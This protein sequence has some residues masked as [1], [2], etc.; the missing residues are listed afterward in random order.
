MPSFESAMYENLM[1]TNIKSKVNR[2]AKA[3]IK[4]NPLS[5]Y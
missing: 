5:Y 2:V 4:K 3:A 1:R